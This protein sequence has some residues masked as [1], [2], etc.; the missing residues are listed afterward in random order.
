MTLV[1]SN[2]TIKEIVHRLSKQAIVKTN[3]KNIKLDLTQRTNVLQAIRY[4]IDGRA[5]D[6]FNE[7]NVRDGLRNIITD[8]RLQSLLTGWYMTENLYAEDISEEGRFAIVV[9]FIN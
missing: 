1:N 8:P 4:L 3:W 5:D 2:C 6:Q 9:M 7:H